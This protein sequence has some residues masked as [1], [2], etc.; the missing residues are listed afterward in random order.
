[1]TMIDG[2]TADVY[3]NGFAGDEMYNPYG[4]QQ[5]GIEHIKPII[6]RGI[7]IDIA[8]SKNVD[9]LPEQYDVSMADVQ[10]ALARQGMSEDDLYAGDALLFIVTPLREPPARR[11]A[12]SRYVNKLRRGLPRYSLWIG[13]HC[14]NV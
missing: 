6:T 5:L 2:S 11:F 10:N 12:L 7:L 1:M 13:D 3:Y 8:G 9:S 4:L 14:Y